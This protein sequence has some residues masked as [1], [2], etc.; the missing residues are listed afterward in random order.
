MSASREEQTAWLGRPDAVVCSPD[1]LRRCI[2][3]G[4]RYGDG[5]E[6]AIAWSMRE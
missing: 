1:E 5:G 4:T 6:G 3:A 2:F